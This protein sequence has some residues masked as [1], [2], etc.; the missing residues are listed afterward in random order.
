MTHTLVTLLGRSPKG[1]GSYRATCYDFGDGKPC[2]EYAFFGWALHRRRHPGR[3]VILGTAG[4]MWDHLFEGDIHLGGKAEEERLALIDTVDDERP[5]TQD[6]LDALAPLLADRLDCELR[7]Q[8]IP[9]CRDEREQNELLRI[10]AANV[11]DGDVVDL[12]ITHGFRHLPMLVLLS[13]LH[14]RRVRGATI[15]HIWYAAFDPDT[16]Q[17]P[18][19]D[20]AGLLQ[21]ADWLEVLSAYEQTG[22]YGLFAQ[23]IGGDIGDLLAEAGFLETVNRIGQAR[24]CLRKVLERLDDT[25]DDPALGLFRDELRRRIGWAGSDNFYLRQRELAFEYLRR[26]RYRDAILTGWEAFTSR[27]QQ[28][29]GGHLDPDNPEHRQRIRDEFDERERKKTP[30]SE[31][32][33][34]FDALRRLRNTVAHGSRPKG[35]EVQRALSSPQTMTKL[36]T[37]LFARLLPEEA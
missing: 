6:L 15:A 4:S 35:N 36:L 3:L 34:A 24:S 33:R 22:D 28:Q 31:R 9:Y 12:D 13:A 19:H 23:L 14:L 29:A 16:K 5:V 27:L 20:L 10:L 2:E 11:D 37:D 17:A 21:I 18:V 25:G 32:Y 8:L 1:Q 26:S 30:R 7:L